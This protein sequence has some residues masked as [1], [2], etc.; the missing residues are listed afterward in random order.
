[1]RGHP[2]QAHRGRLHPPRSGQRRLGH[3]RV[4]PHRRRLDGVDHRGV[5]VAGPL[6]I[7]LRRVHR[8]AGR[9]VARLARQ[10]DVD[11]PRRR[12]LGLQG[13]LPRQRGL[14]RRC[15]WRRWRQRYRRDP[16]RPVHHVRGGHWLEPLLALHL[17]GGAHE[18]DVLLCQRVRRLVGQ[19]PPR[20]PRVHR[21]H[22][23]HV[24]VLRGLP[25]RLLQPC[26]HCAVGQPR[27]DH[28]LWRARGAPDRPQRRVGGQPPGRAPVRRLGWPAHVGQPV[29]VLGLHDRGVRPLLVEGH[30]RWVV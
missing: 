29:R 2:V 7:D 12:Q 5:R 28:P 25:A 8:P 26:L 24:F 17:R 1:M 30:G 11:H 9:L 10:R 6:H 3:H 20:R 13:D 14:G 15:E 21:G 22:R 18:P 19:P 27:H 16:L 4:P 23:R